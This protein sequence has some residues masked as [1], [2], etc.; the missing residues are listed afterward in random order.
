MCSKEAT[1][2]TQA[3]AQLQLTGHI[4][5][6]YLSEPLSAAPVNPTLKPALKKQP[7]TEVHTRPAKRS[8]EQEEAVR[9]KEQEEA[10][11]E[12]GVGG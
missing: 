6:P 8:Q 5:A 11:E 10:E 7:A 2:Q 4:T 3:K 9:E 12:E 1:V